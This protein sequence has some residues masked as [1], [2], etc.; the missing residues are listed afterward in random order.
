MRHFYQSRKNAIKFTDN[1]SIIIGCDLI[2]KKHR[3]FLQFFVK[4]TG[5]GI[6]NNKRNEIFKRFIQADILNKK[7]QNGSGLGLAIS[8]AYVEMLGG[9]IWVESEVGQG[10]TF[11][12]QLRIFTIQLRILKRM[13]W[14]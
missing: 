4:D 3:P 9:Q 1:G 11:I 10:S 2:N 8:K 5:I 14:F 13:N 7:A 6:A 12:L